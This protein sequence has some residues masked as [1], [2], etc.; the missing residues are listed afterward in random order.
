MFEV[1]LKVF[2]SIYLQNWFH[3]NHSTGHLSWFPYRYLVL[4][5]MLMGSQ[6]NP[7]DGQEAKP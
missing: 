2:V 7:F 5:N 1:R 3:F 4:A 6:V